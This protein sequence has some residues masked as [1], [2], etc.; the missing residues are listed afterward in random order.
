MSD[1]VEDQVEDDVPSVEIQDKREVIE[2]DVE[3]TPALD[4]DDPRSAIYKKVAEQR[5]EEIGL[6]DEPEIDVEDEPKPDED[7]VVKVNGKERKVPKS[8]VDAAGGVEAYQK[9]A[10]ASELLNQAS[11]EL[12]RVKEY[13]AQVAAKA[14]QLMQQEKELQH[15]AQQPPVSPPAQAPAN[16]GAMKELARKYHEAIM[17]G[18]IDLADDLLVRMQAARTATPDTDE[19]AR[20][21]A[22]TARQEIERERQQERA[23]SL[24]KERIEAVREFEENFSDV[25]DDPELR[26]MADRKTLE[27]M[28]T[29][30]DWTPKAIIKEAATLVRSWARDK[31][32]SQGGSDK[33]AAKRQQT[34]IRSGSARA[35]TRQAPP[36]PTRSQYVE[37]LRKARGLE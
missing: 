22:A 14:S 34:S 24:E 17:E 33:I 4:E 16:T 9:N 36:P 10:A 13:E 6:V 28:Q 35:M 15:R 5:K 30:P 11:A 7:V 37:S 25:A 23:Q 2:R 1:A 20:K 18:D 8:K 3:E 31:G 26:N 29:H 12:R 27:I 32:L 21:A 19:I